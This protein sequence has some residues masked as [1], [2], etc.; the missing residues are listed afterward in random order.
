MKQVSHQRLGD[1]ADKQ[2]GKGDPELR[3]RQMACEVRDGEQ[4]PLSSRIA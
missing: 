4:Q 3:G 2:R 1:E